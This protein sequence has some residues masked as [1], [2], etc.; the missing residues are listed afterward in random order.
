[1]RITP[2]S[3]KGNLEGLDNK[4]WSPTAKPMVPEKHTHLR[5]WALKR[6]RL[7]EA[8][9]GGRREVGAQAARLRWVIRRSAKSAEA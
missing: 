1:M 3:P 2:I 5:P 7:R 9:F 6:S 8:R 4:E